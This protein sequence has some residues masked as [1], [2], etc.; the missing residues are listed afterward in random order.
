MLT[1]AQVTTQQQK[2]L[3]LKA[4]LAQALSLSEEAT[5]PVA[6]D[7]T[8]QGRVSRGDALQQQEMAKASHLLNRKRL[9]KVEQALSRI[10]AGDYGY[11]SDCDEAINFGRLEIMP[12]ADVCIACRE[13]EEG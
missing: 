13:K 10:D 1:E 7:Q 9:V 5:K 12:E 4:E 8:L 3:K 2:L 6:L 11:C